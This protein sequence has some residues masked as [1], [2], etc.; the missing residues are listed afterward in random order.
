MNVYDFLTPESRGMVRERIRNNE[1]GAIDVKVVRKNG[2][3]RLLRARGKEIAWKGKTAR[4]SAFQDI[5]EYCNS[6]RGIARKRR[7]SSDTG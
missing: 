3:I 5:T 4:M 7:A 2:E 1:T 6:R